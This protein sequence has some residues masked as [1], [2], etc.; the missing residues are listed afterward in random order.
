MT[1]RTTRARVLAAATAAATAAGL[2]AGTAPALADMSD[3]GNWGLSGSARQVTATGT[4]DGEVT[5]TCLAT[6]ASQQATVYSIGGVT[7]GNSTSLTC[8]S[9]VRVDSTVNPQGKTAE[10][11]TCTPFTVKRPDSGWNSGI[12]Q[13]NYD[14]LLEAGG[15][16]TC[17]MAGN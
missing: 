1:F 4:F 17:S 12:H 2:L 7:K 11:T 3:T 8:S 9:D 15:N 10:K 14:S 16:V 13:A 6:S 5:I